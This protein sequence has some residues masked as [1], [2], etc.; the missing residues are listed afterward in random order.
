MNRRL[1]TALA[2]YALLIAIGVWRLHGKMLYALLIVFG[3][4]IV[5]TLVA[6]RAGWTFHA[7]TQRSEWDSEVNHPDSDSAS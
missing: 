4:L 7:E 5:K 3:G 6:H 2:G 1:T